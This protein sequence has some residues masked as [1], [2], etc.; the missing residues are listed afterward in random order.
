MMDTP[1]QISGQAIRAS[2]TI[3]FA[4]NPANGEAI[5]LNGTTWTFVTSGASPTETNIQGSLANTLSQLVEDLNNSTDENV[6]VATYG[7]SGG[8]TLTITHDVSG[9]DGNSYTLADDGSIDVTRSGDSLSGGHGHS[10]VSHV[11]IGGTPMAVEIPKRSDGSNARYLLL[12]GSARFHFMPGPSGI[13]RVLDDMMIWPED[14]PICLNVSGQTHILLAS[15]GGTIDV[16]MV[17][18]GNH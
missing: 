1:Y 5:T 11:Q 3:L 15:D 14:T 7:E 2:G 13:D 4:D 8:D 10:G 6:E 18:L 17:A 16:R 9:S 12:A